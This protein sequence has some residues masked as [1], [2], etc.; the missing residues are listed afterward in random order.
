M[1]PQAPMPPDHRSTPAWSP[2]REHL[3]EEIIVRN[4]FRFLP[5]VVGPKRFCSRLRQ[6]SEVLPRVG[7]NVVGLTAHEGHE[8]YVHLLQHKLQVKHTSLNV[9]RCRRELQLN[10]LW[11]DFLTCSADHC[12]M[13]S[14]SLITPA[15][16]A[17]FSSATAE[18]LHPSQ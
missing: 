4:K 10:V 17:S 1:V 5:P 11:R 3:P 7:D 12:N 13:T 15:K 6:A 14:D 2:N 18:N 9:R 8:S 16:N